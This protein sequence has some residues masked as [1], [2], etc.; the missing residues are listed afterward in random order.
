MADA[1]ADGVRLDRWRGHSSPAPLQLLHNRVTAASKHM[2]GCIGPLLLLLEGAYTES[3]LDNSRLAIKSVNSATGKG[4]AKGCT[5]AAVCC[6]TRWIESKGPWGEQRLQQG[7]GLR[8]KMEHSGRGIK[9]RHLYKLGRSGRGRQQP[10]KNSLRGKQGCV[11]PT[12]AMNQV[13]VNRRGRGDC[14]GAAKFG[15]YKQRSD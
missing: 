8:W 4:R 3:L 6:S 12:A 13:Q 5:A 14:G 15:K 2:V 11:R 9:G 10:P 1:G 7:G